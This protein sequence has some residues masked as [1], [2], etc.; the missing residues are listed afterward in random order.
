MYH[1][2]ECIIVEGVYDKIKLSQFIDATIFVTHGFSVFNNKKDCTSIKTLA[3]KC[4]VVILTDSDSAGFK[5]R[6]F[7][8][9]F[10]PEEYVKHAYIPEIEGKERRKTRRG[11][12][13]ILGVEGISEEIIIAALKNAGCTFSDEENF[14]NPSQITKTDFF[15]LGLTGAPDS[16]KKRTSLANSLNL[17]SKIS[18][19]M[20]LDAINSIMTKAELFSLCEE[21]FKK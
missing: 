6:N 15:T 5:I 20:L 21:L 16:K 2:K 8:K 19:N 7:I 13:G 17:P 14:K 4:G 10:L 1:I 3:E 12:E 18:A 9:Q 11:K